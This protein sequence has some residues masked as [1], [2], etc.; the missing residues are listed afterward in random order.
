[1]MEANGAHL[2]STSKRQGAASIGRRWRGKGHEVLIFY[3]KPST[4]T[5]RRHE[6]H[7]G[8]TLKIQER[9]QAQ[10]DGEEAQRGPTGDWW[11]CWGECD[12]GFASTT[13]SWRCRRWGWIGL[14]GYGTCFSQTSPS[15]GERLGGHLRP[16]QVSRRK[17][18]LYP[19]KPRGTLPKEYLST[20]LISASAN[21]GE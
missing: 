6:R 18:L 13:K 9:C 19:E 16:T 20:I 3:H 17:S 14:E 11:A 8:I 2:G 5:R 4:P 1:V 21:E 12:I 7:T 15:E 10:T